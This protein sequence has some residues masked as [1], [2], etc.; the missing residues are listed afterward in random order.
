MKRVLVC[1]LSTIFLVVVVPVLADLASIEVSPPSPMPVGVTATFT[2]KLDPNPPP[3][4]GFQWYWAPGDCDKG[5]TKGGSAQVF[6]KAMSQVGSLIYQCQGI[7]PMPPPTV[8]NITVD[9]AE[10]TFDDVQS[11]QNTDQALP[12][13]GYSMPKVKFVTYTW[14]GEAGAYVNGN[15]EQRAVD[16]N[17]GQHTYPVMREGNLT[18]VEFPFRDP[19]NLFHQVVNGQPFY[20]EYTKTWIRCRNWCDELLPWQGMIT[21]EATWYRVN[22]NQWMVRVVE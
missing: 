2:A 19:D 18:V 5:W 14:A 22:Q 6:T 16:W 11:Q 17:G 13:I 1:M 7:H 15:F 21:R 4:V 3:V 8:K 10:P 9:V 20:R 12:L